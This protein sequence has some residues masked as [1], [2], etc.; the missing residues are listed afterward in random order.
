[1]KKDKNLVSWKDVK[2]ILSG[3]NSDEL[4]TLINDLYALSKENKNFI[5][6]RYSITGDPLKPYK[7]L[8]EQSIYPDFNKPLKLS[9]GRKAISDYKKAIGDPIGILELMVFYIECGNRF[10]VDYADIDEQFYNSV[11]SMFDKVI[12]ILNKSKQD[13]IDKF[14]PRLRAIVKNAHG[15]GWGYYDYLSDVLEESFPG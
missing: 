14:L 15:I 9:V 3:K 10:T 2:Q 12:K 6:A 5:H 11:E 7:I 8:I 1:M 13:I 4:L